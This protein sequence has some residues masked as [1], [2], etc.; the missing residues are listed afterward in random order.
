MEEENDIMTTPSEV[1]ATTVPTIFL[2]D[3]E[4]DQDD[5]LNPTFDPSS[6]VDDN[7]APRP[8]LSAIFE[9]PLEAGTNDTVVFPG[10]QAEG[11][12]G[13]TRPE[14]PPQTPPELFDPNI[15][16]WGSQD[17]NQPR[18]LAPS[19]QEHPEQNMAVVGVLIALI[20]V[21][22]VILF[23]VT[24]PP[25]LHMIRRKMPIPK[26]RIDR[27]YATIDAWLVRKVSLW[28]F[29]VVHTNSLLS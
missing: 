29:G 6:L 4:G 24:I 19:F 11:V 25:L 23:V 26:A 18:P 1:N 22:I 17:I 3:T 28:C 7:Q 27:R 15:H 2:F 8:P 9:D 12:G 13:K 14:L 20:C 16:P 5:I 10:E 21:L